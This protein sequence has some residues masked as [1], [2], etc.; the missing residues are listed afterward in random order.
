MTSWITHSQIRTIISENMAYDYR[1]SHP[2][3]NGARYF[4]DEESAQE[5]AKN[6]EKD[7]TVTKIQNN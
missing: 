7:L 6:H 4:D 5:Y 3:I 1:A 2:S